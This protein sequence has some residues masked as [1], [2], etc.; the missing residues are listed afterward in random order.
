MRH[1]STIATNY[2]RIILVTS[3]C[4]RVGSPTAA[5][6]HD[7]CHMQKVEGQGTQIRHYNHKRANTRAHTHTQTH[8]H[9]HTYECELAAQIYIAESSLTATN[10]TSWVLSHNSPCPRAHRGRS[11]TAANANANSAAPKTS[12]A[13]F[14]LKQKAAN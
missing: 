12:L 7:P 6:K 3:L 4:L 5:A 2:Q 14:G 8:T 11:D 13:N 1:P 10:K 9:T